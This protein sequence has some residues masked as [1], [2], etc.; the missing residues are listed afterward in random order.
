MP[1]HAVVDAVYTA[2][3]ACQEKSPKLLRMFLPGDAVPELPKT[4]QILCPDLMELAG[5]GPSLPLLVCLRRQDS[6][7]R[8]GHLGIGNLAAGCDSGAACCDAQAFWP[9]WDRRNQAAF[10][11]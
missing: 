5:A 10:T 6:L 4:L 3:K 9:T 2:V 8:V 1:T 7:G 11:Y